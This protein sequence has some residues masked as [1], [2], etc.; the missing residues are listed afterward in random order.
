MK[1][2]LFGRTPC[3]EKR[4]WRITVWFVGT[5]TTLDLS[6]QLNEKEAKEFY[7]QLKKE[8][9]NNKKWIEIVRDYGKNREPKTWLLNKDNI[10]CFKLSDR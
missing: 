1:M 8:L 3:E 10:E 5:N 9:N 6:E 4:D 7:K 2:G